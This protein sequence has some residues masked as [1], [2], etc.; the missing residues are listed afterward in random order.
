MLG[1]YEKEIQ[2]DLMGLAA[3]ARTF[4]NIGCADGYYT[5]GLAGVS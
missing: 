2:A 1:T 4:L 5:T 3:G